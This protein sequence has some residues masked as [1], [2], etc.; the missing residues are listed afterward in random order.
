MIEH[1]EGNIVIVDTDD[2][3]VC[4]YCGI[5]EVYMQDCDCSEEVITYLNFQERIVQET[6]G[7]KD[8]YDRILDGGRC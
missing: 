1:N 3:M 6:M 5:E 4:G 7:N 2:F 8:E